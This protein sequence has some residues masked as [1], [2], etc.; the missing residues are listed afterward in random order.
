VNLGAEL[1]GDR[2]KISWRE[3]IAFGADRW[4]NDRNDLARTEAAHSKG[5]LFE[6]PSCE[7]APSNVSDADYPRTTGKANERAV[8]PEHRNRHV[9]SRSNDRVGVGVQWTETF[10]NCHNTV[11]VNLSNKGPRHIDNCLLH[12]IADLGLVWP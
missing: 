9:L 3:R 6:D 4:A 1:S 7:A 8:R 5:S 10:V 2:F 12:Q 11:S